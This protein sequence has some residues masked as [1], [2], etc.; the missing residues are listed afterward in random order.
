M[1]I[2]ANFYLIMQIYANV[3]LAMQIYE[4]F[5]KIFMKF[6]DQAKKPWLMSNRLFDLNVKLKSSTLENLN[7]LKIL[8]ILQDP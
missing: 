3:F 6:F 4:N 5:M 8:D 7:K 1:Q 2:Y